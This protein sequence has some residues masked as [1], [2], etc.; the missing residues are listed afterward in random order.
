MVCV[1][2]TSSDVF[3]HL[4]DSQAG[5]G[6]DPQP[7]EEDVQ[8]H[9]TGVFNLLKWSKMLYVL[10]LPCLLFKRRVSGNANPTSNRYPILL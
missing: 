1:M 4:I 3:L 10:C 5:R 8:S 6:V 9:V 7:T 2:L